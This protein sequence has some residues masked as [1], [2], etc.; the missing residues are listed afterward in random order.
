MEGNL[1]ELIFD[2][3]TSEYKDEINENKDFVDYLKEKTK[4]ELLSLYLL[5]GYAGNNEY[6]AEEIVELQDNKKEVIKRIVNFLDNQIVSILQFLN[7]GR[8][9]GLKNIAQCE[10]FYKFKKN[11]KNDISFNTIKILKQLNFIFCKK[12][13]DGIVIHMPKFIRDKVNNIHGNLYLDYYDA[14]ITYSKG[15]ADTYGAIH[16]QE[17]Y[18]IIKNDILIS[19][20]KYENIIKFVSLLELEPIYYSF[21]YQCLCSFNLRDERIAEILESSEYTVIYNKP[22]Y[23][24]MGNDN[25]LINLKEYKEFRNFLIEYFGFDINEDE[26]LRGEIVCDYIDTAQLDEKEAKEN[27]WNALDRY[28]EIDD[29][30]KQIIIGYVDKIRKKMP[31]WKQGGKIDNT[32]QFPKVG[33]NELCPCRKWQKV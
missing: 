18:D 13:K 19:F 9:E 14:I 28:F 12:E 21:E 6:I 25:Y 7:D 24:D 23:E 17:A 22:M 27:V 4:H 11:N 20:N 10:G 31:I 8:I 30:E 33:R 32:I 16:I 29:I 1:G 26:L 15:I 5:Y 3:M 2:I